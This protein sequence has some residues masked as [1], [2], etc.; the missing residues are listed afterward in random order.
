MNLPTNNT[1]VCISHQSENCFWR[2]PAQQNAASFPLTHMP[3]A[4]FAD[5]GPA[6][7]PK[8]K[9]YENLDYSCQLV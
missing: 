5:E 6:L 4:A 3:R 1:L 8:N 7:L 2:H 9:K